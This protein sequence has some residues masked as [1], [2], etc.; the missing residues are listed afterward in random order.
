MCAYYAIA[1][2][3]LKRF[4]LSSV[5]PKSP[6]THDGIMSSTQMCESVHKIYNLK[7]TTTYFHVCRVRLLM[8]YLCPRLATWPQRWLTT[9]S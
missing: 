8:S 2:L 3:E 9:V 6:L 1:L 5:V 7:L 4:Y